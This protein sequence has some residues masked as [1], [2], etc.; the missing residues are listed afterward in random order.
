[1]QQTFV[2]H[3]TLYSTFEHKVNKKWKKSSFT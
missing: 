2:D 1:M 3:N